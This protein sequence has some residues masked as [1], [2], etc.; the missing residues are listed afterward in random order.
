MHCVQHLSIIH[1]NSLQCTVTNPTHNHPLPVVRRQSWEA[2]MNSRESFLSRFFWVYWATKLQVTTLTSLGWKSKVSPSTCKE[3]CLCEVDQI[4]LGV[5]VYDYLKRDTLFFY[6][7]S[8]STYKSWR[9][10]AGSTKLPLLPL[11]PLLVTAGSQDS[12]IRNNLDW[13]ISKSDVSFILCF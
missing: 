10:G 5:N 6:T 2:R 7:V 13:N 12:W 4:I 9:Q 11:L 8:C 3:T 1:C